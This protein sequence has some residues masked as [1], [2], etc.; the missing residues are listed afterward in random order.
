MY[1]KIKLLKILKITP[2]SAQK[3]PIPP[4]WQGPY[5][6]RILQNQPIFHTTKIVQ[7]LCNTN[8]NIRKNHEK[9]SLT[10]WNFTKYPAARPLH[11][12]WGKC[13][14]ENPDQVDIRFAMCF[15]DVSGWVSVN[16]F[17]ALYIVVM[18]SYKMDIL[19]ALA[20]TNKFEVLKK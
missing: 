16:S 17:D 9:T 12:R 3:R 8:K 1:V 20:Q 7:N 18:C 19:Y 2:F 15:P 4:I 13:S 14:H 6:Q 11:R 10:W 5:L